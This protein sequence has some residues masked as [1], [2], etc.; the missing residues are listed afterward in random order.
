MSRPPVSPETI[1]ADHTPPIRSLAEAAWR[2]VREIVPEAEEAGNTGWHSINYRHPEVGY[3]FGIFPFAEE[4]RLVFEWGSVL[5]DPAG[6]LEGDTRRVKSV[7]LR[8]RADFDAKRAALEDLLK[9]AIG[10]GND[11]VPRPGKRS[12]SAR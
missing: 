6:V 8:S 4:V 7:F 2:L 12:R 1:L 9:Q 3:F 11:R 5:D 10:L